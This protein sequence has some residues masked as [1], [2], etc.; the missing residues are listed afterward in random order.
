ML[1]ERSPTPFH[2]KG[3]L[4]RTFIISNYKGRPQLDIKET[5]IS[6]KGKIEF[7]FYKNLLLGWL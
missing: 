1:A 3:V 6:E 5:K 2:A 4:D 7:S